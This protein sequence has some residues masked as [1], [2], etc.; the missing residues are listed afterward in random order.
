MEGK[1]VNKTNSVKMNN[2]APH[3]CYCCGKSFKVENGIMMEDAFEATKEWGYFSERDL[4]VHHFVLCE[5]CYDK[6]I[7]QFKV[8]V[9]VKKKIEAL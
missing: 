9:E 3:Y 8:P 6:L 1:V 7:S 2:D 4:E 5:E